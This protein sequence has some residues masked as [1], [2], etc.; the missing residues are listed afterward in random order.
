M[1]GGNDSEANELTGVPNGIASVAVTTVTWAQTAAIC[2]RD[3]CSSTM[4]PLWARMTAINCDGLAAA[5]E[6][7]EVV[8]TARL[9]ALH[10][11]LT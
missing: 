4:A 8:G 9:I 11:T 3:A 2:S 6:R 1:G 7:R 10:R 5:L